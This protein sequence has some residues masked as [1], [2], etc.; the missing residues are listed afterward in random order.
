MTVENALKTL[1]RLGIQTIRV[2]P[3][4]W[5]AKG[6]DQNIH[7]MAGASGPDYPDGYKPGSHVCL[8]VGNSCP[9]SMRQAL[10]WAGI[11][12]PIGREVLA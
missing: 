4:Y 6:P 5:T 12:T 9:T 10:N 1:D 8:V 7:I 2:A 11:A 3:G